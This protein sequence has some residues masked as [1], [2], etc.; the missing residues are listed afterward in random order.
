[1]VLGLLL[2]GLL[3]AS[4]QIR[5]REEVGRLLPREAVVRVDMGWLLLVMLGAIV[6]LRVLPAARCRH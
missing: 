2:L 4:C 1:M 5:G 3:V 6:R